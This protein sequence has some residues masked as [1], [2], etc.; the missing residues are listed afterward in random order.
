MSG[1]FVHYRYP[2]H[3]NPSTHYPMQIY[4]FARWGDFYQYPTHFLK[5][6]GFGRSIPFRPYFPIDRALSARPIARVTQPTT[7]RYVPL[8]TPTA[9]NFPYGQFVPNQVGGDVG[10]AGDNVSFDQKR[11]DAYFNNHGAATAENIRKI[12]GSNTTAGPHTRKNMIVPGAVAEGGYDLP[13]A[14]IEATMNQYQDYPPAMRMTGPLGTS[15]RDPHN[16]YH[17][18]TSPPVQ[19]IS[20]QFA[21]PDELAHH[22]LQVQGAVAQESGVGETRWKMGWF[23]LGI[24]VILTV[25]MV[26]AK[27]FQKKFY[28][29]RS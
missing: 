2:F 20:S 1:G 14:F 12:T 29:K 3:R 18:Q 22:F 4:P 9:R 10:A 15:R 23:V 7:L 16:L 19:P 28:Q 27:L 25:L 24:V 5:S 6:Y 8:P 13:E 21:H 26:I 17:S 11:E